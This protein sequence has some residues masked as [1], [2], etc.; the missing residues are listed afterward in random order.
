MKKM[1]KA[2][3]LDRDGVL[4]EEVNYL[5]SIEQVKLIGTAAEALNIIRKHGYM[6][7]VVSN[8]SGVARGYFPY[9]TVKSVHKHIDLL[10]ENSGTKPV[11]GYFFCPHHPKGIVPEYSVP[12]ECRKPKPGLI[13]EAA[14][15]YNIDLGQS[16]MIGDKKSDI[17]AAEN[18]GLKYAVMVRTGHGNVE[19]SMEEGLD[20][21]LAS[22]IKEAVLY[23]INITSTCN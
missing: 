6:C 1:N 5:N 17:K 3:F 7:I 15:K 12:C 16:F 9:D 18:A 19:S 4:I 23:C 21:H 22:D 11:D 13:F 8:Q 10:L 2:F 14:A 20:T